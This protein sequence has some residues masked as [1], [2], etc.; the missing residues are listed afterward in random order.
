MPNTH[1]ACPVWP[2][3]QTS[4]LNLAQCT[5]WCLKNYQN[6]AITCIAPALRAQ[7]PCYICGPFKKDPLQLLCNKVCKDTSA[8]TKNCGQ[9]GKTVRYVFYGRLTISMLYFAYINLSVQLATHV[10]PG[11]VDVPGQNAATWI[12]HVGREQVAYVYQRPPGLDP[13]F[14][15]G[16]FVRTFP[17]ANLRM[18][19]PQNRCVQ[20]TLVAAGMFASVREAV[21]LVVL[22]NKLVN[23]VKRHWESR[24]P[25]SVNPSNKTPKTTTKRYSTAS[26]SLEY[27]LF[28]NL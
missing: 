23:R 7:G 25:S 12:D 21:A 20:L 18:I 15:E 11:N 16:S 26:K 9:C 24:A 14:L 4:P 5:T 10:P 28:L 6:P 17:T 8:D 13:A 22:R 2:L 27:L 1:L 19:A 3:P